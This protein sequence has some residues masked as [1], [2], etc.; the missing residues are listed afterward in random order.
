MITQATTRL[1][2]LV[3][4]RRLYKPVGL[5]VGAVVLALSMTS[6]GDTA[7]GRLGL[8]YAA[9]SLAYLLMP[10]ARR[11]DIPLVAAWVV[12]LSELAPCLTGQLL[13]PMNVLADTFGVVMAAGPIFI[14]RYRQK[15]QGDVRPGGRRSADA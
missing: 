6:I 3:L 14:A 15:Q 8:F 7:L 1:P 5:V 2:A 10:F 12:L 9:T 4:P 11:T 13:A